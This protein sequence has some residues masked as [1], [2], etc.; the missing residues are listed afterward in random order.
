[1][2]NKKRP[3]ITV[4]SVNSPH[5]NSPDEATPEDVASP[6]PLLHQVW[7]AARPEWQGM[8]LRKN[9][10][11]TGRFKKSILNPNGRF[12]DSI[13]IKE[14]NMATQAVGNRNSR[15]QRHQNTTNDM[16]LS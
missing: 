10:V 8:E 11:E 3:S 6:S 9:K 12:I 5:D 13:E 7:K 2:F 1:M 15:N 4:M 14:M 16:R